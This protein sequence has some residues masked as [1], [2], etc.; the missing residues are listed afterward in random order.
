MTSALQLL[1]EFEASTADGFPLGKE[2]ALVLNQLERVAKLV[3]EAKA[4]Y[5]TQLAQRSNCVPGW[6]LRPGAIRRSLADPQ[7][8]WERVQGVMS[9]QQFLAAVKVEVGKLQDIWAS[10]SG[11]SN[12]QAKEAFNRE[13]SDLVIQLPSAPSLV[14]TAS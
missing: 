12:A 11:I 6:T 7:A 10:T 1:A 13:L 3:E 9:S 4:Y 14:R 5:K 2:G 8:V